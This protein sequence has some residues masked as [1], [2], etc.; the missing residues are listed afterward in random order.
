MNY[1]TT[2]LVFASNSKTAI[3]FLNDVSRYSFGIQ[4]VRRIRGKNRYTLA[5]LGRAYLVGALQQ[6]CVPTSSI[7]ELFSRIHWEAFDLAVD[8]LEVGAIDHLYVVFLSFEP[9]ED[10]TG[11]VTNPSDLPLIGEDLGHFTAI[12][13]HD[14]LKLKLE[15]FV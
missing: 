2:D 5:A 14:F 8:Q 9:D 7:P 13:L 3:H 6:Q 11:I 1:L 15:G 4:P 10:F 12:G